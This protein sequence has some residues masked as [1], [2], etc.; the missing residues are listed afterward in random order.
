MDGST[1]THRLFLK[2]CSCLLVIRDCRSNLSLNDG[3]QKRASVEFG[4]KRNNKL[5]WDWGF[6]AALQSSPLHWNW[7]KNG[8]NC[9]HNKNNKRYFFVCLFLE[10][11]SAIHFS[12]T[13]E[14]INNNDGFVK[15]RNTHKNQPILVSYGSTHKTQKKKHIAL[16]SS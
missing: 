12:K 3:M 7:T 2:K 9:F 15:N 14:S 16:F 4:E 11:N 8:G 6:N 13:K 1:H 10:R 5:V